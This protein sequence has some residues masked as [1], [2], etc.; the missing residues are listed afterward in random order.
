VNGGKI[1]T[2]SFIIPWRWCDGDAGWQ[3]EILLVFFLLFSNLFFSSVSYWKIWLLQ[4][5]RKGKVMMMGGCGS[6]SSG[7]FRLAPLRPFSSSVIGWNDHWDIRQTWI[8]VVRLRTL[9]ISMR[10]AIKGPPG[11]SLIPRRRVPSSP[12]FSFPL[13]AW[14]TSKFRVGLTFSAVSAD[15]DKSNVFQW[16]RQAGSSGFPLPWNQQRNVKEL[17]RYFLFPF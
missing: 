15:T 17:S 4:S 9:C 2:D 3:E 13:P 6:E 8:Y 16:D 7:G 10:A 12:P 5:L 14:Q 11:Y 1:P